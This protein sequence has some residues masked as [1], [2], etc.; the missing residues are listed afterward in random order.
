MLIGQDRTGKTSLKRSLKG[1]R[2][3]KDEASTDGVEM[4]LPLLKVGVQAWKTPQ[5]Q[6]DESSTVF[7][8][9]SAQLVA[10]QLSGESDDLPEPT[11][12]IR[13]PGLP[14]QRCAPMN[15]LTNGYQSPRNSLKPNSAGK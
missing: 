1:E 6:G 4:D 7:D 12:E 11:V 14:E 9:R 3:N 2:F 5:G 15:V 8:H 13:S 10:R